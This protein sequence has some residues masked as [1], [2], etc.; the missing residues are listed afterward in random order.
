[1][2][3]QRLNI[4]SGGWWVLQFHDDEDVVWGDEYDETNRPI[5][6]AARYEHVLDADGIP[7][8]KQVADTRGPV[9]QWLV[10]PGNTGDPGHLA[11]WGQVFPAILTDDDPPKAKPI[12][13]GGLAGWVTSTEFLEIAV[14]LPDGMT[15]TVGMFGLVVVGTELGDQNPLFFPGSAG[16]A[17]STLFKITTNND[18]GTYVGH[19]WD[20]PGG[21]ET[22][23]TDVDLFEL[24]FAD[25]VPVDTYVEATKR[26][27]DN[28][29]F[30][31][32]AG[33]ETPA[34]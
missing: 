19:T 31:Y 29:W 4:Q 27:D 1:M 32:P 34:E 30:N 9:G 18:D 26:G 10:W 33:C 24:N 28:Y 2:T 17:G 7:I 14:Y 11:Q 21:S 3:L 6:F 13:T 12:D 23:D 25:K 22:D 20:C 8:F 15:P 16:G 5:N